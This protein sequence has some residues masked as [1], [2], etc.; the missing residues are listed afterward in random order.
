MTDYAKARKRAFWLLSRCTY[1]SKVLAD[2]L[3]R[4]GFSASSVAKVIDDCKRLGFINDEEALLGQL[5]RGYG[6]RYIQYKF[7]ISS[8]EV[9]EVITDERQVEQIKKMRHRFNEREK[10]IRTLLRRGFDSNIVIEIFSY[11]EIE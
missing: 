6:P 9:R 11:Q 2:R 8:D 5:K 1:H 4:K 10:G 3:K 7:Q